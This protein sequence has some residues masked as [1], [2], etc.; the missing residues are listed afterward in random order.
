M[1]TNDRAVSSP[2]AASKPGPLAGVKVIDAATLFACPFTATVLADFGANVIKVEHP[3]GDAAREHGYVQNGISCWWKMFNR[4]K[5]AVTLNF[6]KP[7]GQEIL[8]AL[9]ADAD[10]M[11]EN[12]RP[13]TLER[14]NLG[15]DRLHAHNP[16][17]VLLRTTGFGQFGPYSARAGF[18]TLAE[19]MSGWAFLNGHPDGPPTLPPFGLGDSI[20]GITGAVAVMMALYN[21]DAHGG[22]G[23]MI[24]LA[25]IEP[26][27]TVT[28]PYPSLYD[29]Y[30][31][32]PM[33]MGN[34]SP[35]SSPRNIYQTGDGRWVAVSAS[36][37]SVA[38]RVAHLV[39]H[40]ELIE[41]PWFKSG[42]QR[43]EH[44]DELDAIVGGW[45]G[46]HTLEEV[47]ST[48]SKAEAALMPIYDVTDVMK[49]PQYE[50]LQSIISVPDDDLGQL[51]MQNVMFR[52]S[53]TPG[54][55][56]WT[57]RRKGQDNAEIYGALGI[58]PERLA[59]LSA[60]G[61]I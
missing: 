23:Q 25:L 13:G 33:R 38:E 50:A 36:A 4:S 26:M 35:V 56:R 37:Q 21:R 51:K 14:W 34:R 3:A 58:T 12:F 30:G 53:D 10:V 47:V 18:G 40:P 44:A 29:Q 52:M 49:D 46:E 45:I 20:A 6:S 43:R 17:L 16:K 59:E 31:L 24:D 48:F 11:V 54:T 7:E 27:L 5:Q 22:Q 15:W 28:G 39:G 55:V 60:Q 61:V 57:G 9:L 42:S 41:Q 8:L 2:P 32:V 19:S 1:E